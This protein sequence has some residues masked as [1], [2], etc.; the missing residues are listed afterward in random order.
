MKKLAVLVVTMS[1]VAC[2]SSDDTQ[3]P[4]TVPQVAAPDPRIGELQ[5]SMT[6]LL[7]R[8]DVMNSRLARLEESAAA[9]V[10]VASA[11]SAPTPA[12]VPSDESR[13]GVAVPEN[14][15]QPVQQRALVGAR[16]AEDYRQAIMLFGRGKHAEA[17]RAFQAVLESDAAG[18]LAD[19]A[20]F[21][22]GETYY[23]T[24]DYTNAVRHYSR[25]VNEFPD[26]NKAPDAMFKIA[27]AQERTGDLALARRTFQQVIE[28]YPY[29]S[30]ASSAKAELQRIR[31]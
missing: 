26:Q 18:D 23:A 4:V 16:L 3:A 25:V 12:P 1:L 11:A 5:T 27:L 13:D 22:I 15:V 29:S 2:V 30:T 21:W 10:S 20:L 17:R 19:N 28:R 6:E 8:L 7:D 14:P 31:F 24:G 9:A